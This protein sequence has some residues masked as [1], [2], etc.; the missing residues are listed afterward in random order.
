[1]A[2]AKG[3]THATYA[4]NGDGQRTAKQVG[5]TTTKFATDL[6]EGLPLTV[7]AGTTSYVT[8]P[9]GLPLEQI[10]GTTVL[11]YAHDQL[12]S[13]RL[14][15]N[16]TGAAVAHYTF[17]PYGTL[18]AYSG[19]ATTPFGF[20]GQY[21]DAESGLI[22]MRARYYDPSTAQF[23]SVD[24][25][26]GMTGQPYAYADDSPVDSYDPSGLIDWSTIPGSA[27]NA[28]VNSSISVENFVWQNLPGSAQKVLAPYQESLGQCTQKSIA[29]AATTATLNHVAD[30][31]G[32]GYMDAAQGKPVTGLLT[33]ITDAY[34]PEAPWWTGPAVDAVGAKGDQAVTQGISNISGSTVRY[35]S[36]ALQMDHDMSTPMPPNP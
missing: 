7:Q 12:G 28:V 1:V 35:M 17:T 4:Y 2:F 9:G 31:V 27:W 32:G 25:A 22:Y 33:V 5:S 6:A 15:T 23:I 20:A 13:T 34:F 30:E 19:T 16:A 36:P 10:T 14:L 3:T 21:A 8:G 26:L 11:Y 18:S 29:N 24:P